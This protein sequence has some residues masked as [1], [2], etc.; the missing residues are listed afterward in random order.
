MSTFPLASNIDSEQVLDLIKSRRTCYQFLDKT[1]YPVEAKKITDCL[2]AARY[3]PNHKLT[4]PWFFWVIGEQY[5]TKLAHIYA[6]NRA[7]KQSKVKDEEF[8]SLYQKA[9]DKFNCIPQVILVGQKL[10]KTDLLI[11]EDYAA[12]SCAIQNFKLMAWQQ[13]IGVQW[14]TGPI[15]RDDRTFELLNIDSEEIEIIGAL[16]LGYVD[17][18]CIPKSAANRK[19]VDQI[20]VVTD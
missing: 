12:C 13:K 14:S 3:A 10:G 18:D 17:P 16:Y 20:S 4:Q 7:K 11:K 5:K 8:E 6:D 9:V 1:L 2:E 19:P 15:I